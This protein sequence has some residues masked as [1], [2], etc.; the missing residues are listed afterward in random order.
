[1]PSA[2][3]GG[4]GAEEDT[5][6]I[7]AGPDDGGGVKLRWAFLRYSA[8]LGFGGGYEVG[9]AKEGFWGRGGYIFERF[10]ALREN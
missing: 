4:E 3:D 6:G 1:M 2:A 9:K 5:R 10:K 7:A 8:K